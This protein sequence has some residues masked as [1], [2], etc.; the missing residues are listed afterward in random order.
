MSM[1]LP[2][3]AP[4][5]FPDRWDP[6]GKP[7]AASAAITDA[8]R[9]TQFQLGAD[10]RLLSEGMNL[11]LQIVKDSYPSQYRSLP[12]AV[13]TMYWSRAF[14]AVNDGALALS[15][16]SY[17]SCPLLIRGA[18]EAIAAENQSGGE[19]HELFLAWLSETLQPNEQQRATEVGMGNYFAGST[20]ASNA[21]LGS[22]FRAAAEFSRQHFG[23]TLLETAPESSRQRLAATFADQTFHFGW[24][25]LVL[26]WMLSICLVQLELVLQAGSPFHAEE[27][28]RA[29]ASAFLERASGALESPTRCRV[30]ELVENGTRRYLLHNFRRQSSG[31]PQKLFL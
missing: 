29:A 8:Y 7:D 22:I 9:Q 24:A 11:Q 20:L 2:R 5:V 31:A 13:M 15:R 12:L 17:A 21:R 16:G 19:E 27:E 3:V 30:E 25:Q 18:C 4:I 10:L 14:L 23:V 28:R 1:P 6:P 26:G